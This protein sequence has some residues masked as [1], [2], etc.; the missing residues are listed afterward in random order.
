MTPD[1]RGERAAFENR[2]V[3]EISSVCSILNEAGMRELITRIAD[4]AR[5]RVVDGDPRAEHGA[6]FKKSGGRLEDERVA[7]SVSVWAAGDDPR[8]EQSAF[9]KKILGSE[10]S[11]AA[12][13]RNTFSL[14]SRTKASGTLRASQAVPHPSTDRALQRLTLEFG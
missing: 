8:A 4:I 2:G 11:M 6:F 10:G 14:T 7:G 9:C 13:L 5:V 1:R 3:E 12:V